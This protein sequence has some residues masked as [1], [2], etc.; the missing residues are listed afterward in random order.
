MEKHVMPFFFLS[1]KSMTR[2]LGDTKGGKRLTMR[3]SKGSKGSSDCRLTVPLAP[4]PTSP[5]S[6]SGDSKRRRWRKCCA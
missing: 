3:H 6:A 4:S 5:T 1:E 2:S